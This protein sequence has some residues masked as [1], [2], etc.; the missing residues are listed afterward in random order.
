MMSKT[1]TYLDSNYLDSNASAALRPEARA[2]MIAALD[3]CGN[4]SS[5]HRAGRSARNV[6]EK[7]RRQVAGLV[8]AAPGDVIF[9]SGGTEAIN[10]VIAGAAA[11]GI[12]HILVSE[13]EHAAVLAAARDSGVQLHMIGVDGDGRVLPEILRQKLDELAAPSSPVLVAVMLANNESG[14]IQPVA[15]LAR[16]THAHGGVFL[17]DA[18]QA[19]GKIAVDIKQL[20][21]DYLVLSAHKTGGPQG[22]GALITG[23]GSDTAPLIKGGGQERSRRAGTENLAGIAGFGA[24][25][26]AALAGL[27][28]MQRITQL[29]DALEK[30]LKAL[31]SGIVFIGENAER[32]G[33]TSFFAIPGM[34]AETLVIALDLEGI[35][36]SAGSACSSGKSAASHVPLAMGYNQDTA[37]GAV[38]VSFGWQN[39][40]DDV[41]RFMQALEAVLK[42]VRDKNNDKTA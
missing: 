25:A 11:A 10:T 20:G 8:N 26:E 31:D 24:A 22:V 42:R 32:L 39:N 21:V 38:R 23:C 4:A 6:I 28:D 12:K 29:R 7:A 16:I 37:Q 2:A 35:A 15:G 34:K 18:V 36:I 5:V 19:A 27:D 13:T 9:T 40:M 14:V 33:N 30:R 17:C 41:T 3:I 1:A